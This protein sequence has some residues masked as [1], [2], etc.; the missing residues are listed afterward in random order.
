MLLLPLF[1]G[2]PASAIAELAAAS[3]LRRVSK[4]SVIYYQSDPSDAVYIVLSGSVSILLSHPD[5]R[6][7]VTN[8][9]RPGDCF[10]ELALISGN[11]RSS[12]AIAR[13]ESELL[14]LPRA[15]FLTLL[16]DR[17][18][19]QRRLLELLAARLC[20]STERESALAF[21]D[22]PARLARVLLL[23][24]TLSEHGTVTVSQAELAQRTGLTRQTV[25]LSLGR[26]RRAGWLITGRGHIMLLN[27]EALA[28]VESHP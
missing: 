14:V 27:R 24:D 28:R 19:V 4:G 12:S 16:S 1:E 9:M 10:G 3:R 23:M 17:P 6:E 25:A 22:A 11:S 5:G 13:T 20:A 8:E 21:L 26:W 18:S 15:P 2:C 7:L